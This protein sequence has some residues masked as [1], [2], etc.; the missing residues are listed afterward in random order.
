MMDTM[1]KDKEERRI[2]IRILQR[3][4]DLIRDAARLK[5]LSASAYARMVII[6]VARQALGEAA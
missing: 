1:D 2:N 5:G 6:E 3:D 4:Y